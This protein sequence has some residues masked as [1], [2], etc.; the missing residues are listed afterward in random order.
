MSE[1]LKLAGESEV[2]GGAISDLH[3]CTSIPMRCLACNNEKGNRTF[4]ARE[5]MFGLQESFEYLECSACQSLH[6]I[7]IPQDLA[8][9]YS[10]DYYSFSRRQE[11]V[12]RLFL[13]RQRVEHALGKR[14]AIGAL[15]CA[16]T[17]A[18]E[19]VEWIK[20]AAVQVE[21]AI[22]DV[23]CGAGRLLKELHLAGFKNLTGIDPFLE[24][25]L[26]L[27]G[28]HLRKA[29]LEDLQGQ[30]DFIMLHHSFEHMANP[31]AALREIHRLL[32]PG[33]SALVRCPLAGSYACRT[34]GS[35]WVQLDAPRHLF[36]PSRSGFA[37]LAATCGFE[38]WKTSCDS[39][40]FQF[41]GSE[42]Y[43]RGIPLQSEGRDRSFS[44]LQKRRYRKLAAKLN[45]DLDGDSACFYLRKTATAT[46]NVTPGR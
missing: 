13:K 45:R 42:L 26:D 6:I 25:D 37:N 28:V 5:M 10:N 33:R 16:L 8:K 31:V 4:S 22:L 38:L 29:G 9:Y 14:R 44:Y 17:G 7:D 43:Q 21:D 39:T 36:I 11:S 24:R 2:H 40:E 30:Y 34:Y 27:D 15:L 32:A 35:N 18:P 23:G 1:K 20:T 19:F 41:T 3:A 12:L 46:I